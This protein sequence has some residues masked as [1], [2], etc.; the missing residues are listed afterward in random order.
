VIEGGKAYPSWWIRASGSCED[1]P[2]R[3]PTVLRRST[4][5]GAILATSRDASR[6]IS[7][8]SRVKLPRTPKGS[9]RVSRGAR[10]GGSLPSSPSFF[11]FLGCPR[12]FPCFFF[13]FVFFWG[14]PGGRGGFFFWEGGS[15]GLWGGGGGGGG[16]GGVLGWV[17]KRWRRSAPAGLRRVGRDGNRRC[18]PPHKSLA[19]RWR[20]RVPRVR[21]GASEA[22]LQA[23]FRRQGGRSSRRARR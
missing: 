17:Q 15:G 6:S 5:A 1:H 19:A 10:G 13:F 7:G 4:G 18:G 3:R 14:L 11:C 12:G 22:K 20:E 23:Y 9:G 8:S 2:A 21:A 16:G